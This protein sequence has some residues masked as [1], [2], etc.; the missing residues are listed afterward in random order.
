M[1]S[2]S[3]TWPSDLTLAAE[4]LVLGE[5]R[6]VVGRADRAGVELGLVDLP[7]LVGNAHDFFVA[8]E[9]AVRLVE[10][11]VGDFDVEDQ[12]LDVAFELGPVLVEAE[13]GHQDA[14]DREVGGEAGDDG[15]CW[16]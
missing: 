9:V 16:L 10:L 3:I 4:L 5:H 15:R 14:F 6:V 2:A 13:P 7:G 1:R 8:V 11:P 12:D